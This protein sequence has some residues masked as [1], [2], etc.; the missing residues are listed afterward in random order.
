MKVIAI[1]PLVSHFL[2]ESLDHH[3]QIS[4]SKEGQFLSTLTQGLTSFKH[5]HHPLEAPLLTHVTDSVC[6]AT[7]YCPFSD[8]QAI[9]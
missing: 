9:A 6:R 1:L 8:Q 3:G 5:I 7:A 2:G 4:Q